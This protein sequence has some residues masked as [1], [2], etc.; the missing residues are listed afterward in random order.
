MFYFCGLMTSE[1]PTPLRGQQTEWILLFSDVLGSLTKTFPIIPFDFYKGAGQQ[2][3]S[4]KKKEK[5]KEAR[6]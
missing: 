3:E 2:I 4:N 6:E 5:R 1:V